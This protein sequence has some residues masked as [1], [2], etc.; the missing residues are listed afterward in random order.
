VFT[1]FSPAYGHPYIAI[2][3][4]LENCVS[5]GILSGGREDFIKLLFDMMLEDKNDSQV[6]VSI[7]LY[8]LN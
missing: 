6:C 2:R 7:K 1:F 4:L 5:Q 3:D 8:F